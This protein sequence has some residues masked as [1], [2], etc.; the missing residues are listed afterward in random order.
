[1]TIY[2][3]YSLKFKIMIFELKNIKYLIL[4]VLGLIAKYYKET[5]TISV[6]YMVF[7]KIYRF[8]DQLCFLLR[9]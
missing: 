5:V 2:D 8:C 7:L 1:M 6:L 3:L 4:F 9:T